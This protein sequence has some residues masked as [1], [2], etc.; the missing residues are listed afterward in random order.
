MTYQTVHRLKHK[1][2]QHHSMLPRSELPVVFHCNFTQ[3]LSYSI[4]CSIICHT[5]QMY[6]A[7]RDV[8]FVSFPN[9]NFVRKFEFYSNF[10]Y[11]D[12]RVSLFWLWLYT[13]SILYNMAFMWWCSIVGPSRILLACFITFYV[14]RALQQ[15]QH[16][17]CIIY[18]MRWW[19]LLS[20][21]SGRISIDANCSGLMNDVIKL[22]VNTSTDSHHVAVADLLRE[23]I[24][25]RD[26]FLMLPR[27]FTRDDINDIIFS[28]CLTNTM[29][30]VHWFLCFF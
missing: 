18:F 19:S 3:P 10:V 17:Q 7:N 23:I 9:S 15:K 27:W 30:H 8:P 1:D 24:M 20:E 13:Y 28:M 16:H 2:C 22:P 6:I 21:N 14:R 5:Q 4:H 12:G 29:L 11:A 26:N 25:V